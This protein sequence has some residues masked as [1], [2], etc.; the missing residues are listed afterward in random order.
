MWLLYVENANYLPPIYSLYN[1]GE[2]I[3]EF[4]LS[5][6]RGSEFTVVFGPQHVS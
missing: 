2:I 5:R 1:D 4:H 3:E 6:E